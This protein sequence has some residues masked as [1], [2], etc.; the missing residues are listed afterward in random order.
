MALVERL[1]GLEEPKIPV[2]DFFA[3]QQQVTKGNITVANVKSFLNM[4]AAAAAEYDALVAL[5]PTGTSAAAYFNKTQYIQ[6]CHSVF[7]LAEERYPG[8][9]TPANVRA[10]LGI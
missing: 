1:M 5:Y 4:D 8:Y 7:I 9:D 3:A 6:D 10:K 2:H